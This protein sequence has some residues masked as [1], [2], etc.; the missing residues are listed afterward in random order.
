MYVQHLKYSLTH[1]K[2][3][4][5]LL[6][7]SQLRQAVFLH[8]GH[9]VA[10]LVRRAVGHRQRHLW[11]KNILFY[12][13][14]KLGVKGAHVIVSDYYVTERQPGSVSSGLEEL[15][16]ITITRPTGRCGR[17]LFFSLPGRLP[18]RVL[19]VTVRSTQTEIVESNQVM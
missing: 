8:V 6:E 9:A 14:K 5:L 2:L 17:A 19:L 16:S 11:E 7:G 15:L 1:H 13:L 4:P 12:A 18:A 10:H 3:F